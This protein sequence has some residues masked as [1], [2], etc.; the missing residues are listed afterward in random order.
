MLGNESFVQAP[1]VDSI[2]PVFAIV[3][4][5]CC[6]AHLCLLE[7]D[8][9]MRHTTRR[10]TVGMNP[11]VPLHVGIVES[12]E[13][14]A[15]LFDFNLHSGVMH[16]RSPAHPASCPHPFC[17]R[18]GL[19][20]AHAPRPIKTGKRPF[21][22]STFIH[23]RRGR[24]PP[25]TGRRA[26]HLPRRYRMDSSSNR[27][28]RCVVACAIGASFARWIHSWRTRTCLSAKLRGSTA[29]KTL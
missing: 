9:G 12:M 2:S 27:F 19:L 26:N 5:C 6:F 22:G 20:I 11:C 3:H 16:E 10:A 14:N 18:R 24:N 13:R 29:R 1:N 21:I 17:S 28:D 25:R 4:Y 7:V 23:M 15:W 8:R